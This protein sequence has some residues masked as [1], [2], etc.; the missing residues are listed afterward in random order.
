MRRDRPPCLPRTP[1]L[2]F[3]LALTTYAQTP[4]KG[5][6]QFNLP[7]GSDARGIVTGPD[8][9]L[10]FTERTSGKVGRMDTLGTLTEFPLPGSA[11]NPD[12]IIVGPPGLLAFTFPSGIGFVSLSGSITVYPCSCVPA[13]LTLG[14]DAAVW[15]TD[16]NGSI[17]RVTSN[18]AFSFFSV[19]TPGSAPTGIAAG[20]DG[21]LWFTETTANQIGRITLAGAAT[22]FALPAG[23]TQPISMTLGPGAA[24]WFTTQGGMVGRITTAGA[25]TTYQATYTSSPYLAAGFAPNSITAGSDGALWYTQGNGLGRVTST[26]TLARFTAPNLARTNGLTLGP[27]NA[28]WFTQD[29]SIGRIPYSIAGT[30]SPVITQV[31]PGSI[32]LDSSFT[33][34]QILG[35]GLS[36]NSLACPLPTQVSW[37]GAFVAHFSTSTST[38]VDATVTADLLQSNY[39]TATPAL[40]SPGPAILYV[41]VAGVDGTGNCTVSSTS[42]TVQLT[43][44]LSQ[45]GAGSLGVTQNSLSFSAPG[46]QLPPSQTILVTSASGSIPYTVLAQYGAGSANWIT[47]S[48]T[49]GVVS[50]GSGGAVSMTVSVNSSALLFPVGVYSAILLLTPSGG[51]SAAV[52][53]TITYTVGSLSPDLRFTQNPMVFGAL[54]GAL[55]PPSQALVVS[56]TGAVT[57]FTASTDAAWLQAPPN[58]PNFAAPAAFPISVAPA[59]LAAGTYIGHVTLTAGGFATGH[60]LTVYLVVASTPDRTMS[61]SYQSGG[62]APFTQSFNYAPTFTAAIALG[63]A[64]DANWL[65]AAADQAQTPANITVSVAPSASLSLGTH[66]GVVVATAFSGGPVASIDL[67]TLTVTP[68]ATVFATSGTLAHIADGGGWSTTVILVN[69]DTVPASFTLQLKLTNTQDGTPT[70]PSLGGLGKQS[71]VTGAIPVGGSQTIITDGSAPVLSWGWARVSSQQSVSGTAI[72]R[73]AQPATSA[74]P[75]QE[76]AVPL[77]PAGSAALLFPFDNNPGFVTGIALSVPDATSATTVTELQFT[78]AGQSLTDATKDTLAA[79]PA[80]GHTAFALP[81]DSTVAANLR[82]VAEFDSLGA[83][84]YG[85]G[86]RFNKAAFTSV[87]AVTRQS[88]ATKVITHI[89]DGG[90]WKTTIVL[91]NADIVPAAFIVNFWQDN[92]ATFNVRRVGSTLPQSSVS[93]TI[94]VKGTYTIETLGTAAN[95]TEGWAQILSNQSLG[96][97]AIFASGGQEAAVPFLTTGAMKQV[98]PFDVGTGL[99]LG[100][101]LTNTSLT[102][103]TTVTYTV[104]DES[105]QVIAMRAVDGNNQPV[106]GSLPLPAHQHTVLLFGKPPTGFKELRGTVE[107]DSTITPIYVLGIRANNNAFTSVRAL[108]LP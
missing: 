25:V 24:L 73:Q 16:R 21:A 97:T 88:A 19:P 26:G 107:F 83:P 29:S 95:L 98:V 8:G 17:G 96:G 40:Q 104:R 82:G 63:A 93:G 78:Q 55:A 37:N 30:S 69:T 75:F 71:I 106:S 66:T 80:Q 84:V 89:A 58:A 49:I 38:E 60:S 61:F 100:V 62:P 20:P 72:F 31:I 41:E 45:G 102:Q 43:P 105:G 28:L 3:F 39:G 65:S 32:A 22:E 59:G 76:A 53:V 15:F 11:A 5:I 90:S 44:S 94:P 35:T 27:D 57:T 50:P 47:V 101:A 4:S 6:T 56:T 81:V 92:G 7:S 9:A 108:R 77:L 42:A 79:L 10:W 52:T 54:I 33:A 48:P 1:A 103:D 14:P 86:I 36:G 91:V 51:P 74:V 12:Q 99:S 85:L 46:G 87:E 18:G 34:L 13:G 2:L 70:V 64:S 23:V 68:L 67:V